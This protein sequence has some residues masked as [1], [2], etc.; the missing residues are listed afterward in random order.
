MQTFAEN[1]RT[2]LKIVLP[3]LYV[4]ILFIPGYIFF[5]S[6]GG[7]GFL[8]DSDFHTFASLMFPFFGLLA[9][10]LV[11]M[12]TMIGMNMALFT[13]VFPKMLSFHRTQGLFALLFATTHALAIP[14]VFTVQQYIGYKFLAPEMRIF[15]Y[16]GA[17]AFFLIL[18]TVTVALFRRSRRLRP[19][20]KYIHFLNYAVFLLVLVHS[21]NLGSDVV[22]TPLEHLWNFFLLTFLVSLGFRIARNFTTR[23]NPVTNPI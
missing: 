20:W 17:I 5:S 10:T 15:A 14:Y 2:W 13:K 12:Q 19:I 3:I 7:L 1:N 18:L 4:I 9:F 22:G 8:E 21:R 16:F 11:W 6:R 23:K